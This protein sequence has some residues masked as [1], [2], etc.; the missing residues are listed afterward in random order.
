MQHPR[1]P[2]TGS[3]DGAALLRLRPC[4]FCT[5]SAALEGHAG[6]Y[7]VVC[8]ECSASTGIYDIASDAQDAWNVRTG[9]LNVYTTVMDR[10]TSAMRTVLSEA[11]LA[12]VV[13]ELSR[14]PNQRVE[15]SLDGGQFI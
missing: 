13:R 11:Q 9:D 15:P 14:D 4:P 5:A 7:A 8:Q 10:V 12:L 3:T 2:A 1:N 6:M